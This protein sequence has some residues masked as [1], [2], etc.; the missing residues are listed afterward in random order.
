MKT[1]L[2]FEERSTEVPMTLAWILSDLGESKGKQS[3]YMK[4]SPQGLKRLREH[5]LIESSISSNRLEGVEI[6][7]KR[8]NPVL[9]SN[10]T[11]RDRD[12]GEVRGYRDALRW[13]HERKT[14]IPITM[15]TLQELHRKISPEVADSGKWRLKPCDIIEKYPDGKQRIRF[16]ATAPAQIEKQL[17]QLLQKWEEALT[18]QKIHPLISIS[19]FVFDFLCIHPFRD[20]NGRVSRLLFTLLCYHGGYEAVRYISLERLIEENKEAYYETLEASSQGWHDAKH[21]PWAAIRHHLWILKEVYKEFESR[22]EVYRKGRGTKTERV[23]EEFKRLPNPFTVS[24]LQN[25]CPE[26]SRKMI[27]KILSQ[28]KKTKKVIPLGRGRDT[29]WEKL[30]GN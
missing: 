18:A 2:L 30:L 16:T 1:F 3:L 15:K 17:S 7:A 25:A 4:Q 28:W 11:L 21:D 19:S 9:I 10:K 8:V 26:V 12:E 6:E 20:G 29:Q 22:M 23:E 27:Q 13:I 24:Q 14:G 5:A